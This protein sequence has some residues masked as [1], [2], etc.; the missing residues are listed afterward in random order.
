MQ[1][2]IKSAKWDNRKVCFKNQF[3]QKCTFTI[4]DKVNVVH[5]HCKAK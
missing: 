3:P 4:G 1:A 2:N 5:Y